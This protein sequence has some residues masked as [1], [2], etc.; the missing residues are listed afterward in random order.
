MALQLKNSSEDNSFLVLPLGVPDSTYN[1]WVP[2]MIGTNILSLIMHGYR[3]L[4]T[5]SF[6]R[7]ANLHIGY[8]LGFKLVM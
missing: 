1:Y 7:V 5:A 6:H 8:C 2:L 3:Q 4:Y